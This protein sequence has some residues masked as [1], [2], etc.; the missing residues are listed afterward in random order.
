M[1]A[2]LLLERLLRAPVVEIA[3]VVINHRERGSCIFEEG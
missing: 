1:V 2:E 3:V